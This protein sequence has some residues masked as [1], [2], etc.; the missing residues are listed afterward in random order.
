MSTWIDSLLLL[1]ILTS[2]AILGAGRLETY[3]RIV[4][5]QGVMTSVLMLVAHHTAPTPRTLLL[6][7]ASVILK[8]WLFPVMLRRA[9]KQARVRCEV[10]PYV[11]YNVSVV[12][13]LGMLGLALWMGE[14]LPLPN[15]VVS[16]LLVPAALF[17]ML[18]GLFIIISRHNALTQVLG[19]LVLENGVYVFG[20]TVVQETPFI[21][22]VGVL[23]DVLVAVFVMGIMVFHIAR[24]F[25]DIDTANLSA[26]QDWK[27]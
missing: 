27:R 5:T 22:E 9:I 1:L 3:I 26:L 24:E 20:S 21:V 6:A 10:D 8:A 2:L 13:G 12:L 23:L 17:T 25:D 19:Y 4:A 15:P 11:G 18:A 7:G 16:S 14:L